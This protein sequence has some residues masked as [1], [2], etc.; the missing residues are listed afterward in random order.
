MIT[1]L[2]RRKIA[3]V[4]AERLLEGD[5]TII[6]DLAGYLFYTKQTRSLNLLVRDIENV[7]LDKG[8]LVAKVVSAHDLADS[9]KKQIDAFLLDE[10][11]ADSVQ[12]QYSI[13]KNLIGGIQ[14]STPQAILDTSIKNKLQRLKAAKQ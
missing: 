13:D 11:G 12:V 7:L 5:K 6:K 1:K 3:T 9:V 14:I 4:V 2:S 8:V 10:S